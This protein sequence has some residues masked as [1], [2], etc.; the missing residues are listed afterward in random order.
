MSDEAEPSPQDEGNRRRLR[1]MQAGLEETMSK[2]GGVI[3]DAAA[4]PEGQQAQEEVRRAAHT[5]HAAGKAAAQ[6]ARPH[7][8]A[9][10][11]QVNAEL[12][13]LSERMERSASSAGDSAPPGEQS[14]PPTG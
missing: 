11:R 8:L 2:L 13:K 6:E 7:L 10:L 9:A 5:V 14:D 12:Q 4:S 1:E 3:R